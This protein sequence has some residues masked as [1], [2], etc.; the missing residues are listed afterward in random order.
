LSEGGESELEKFA[1]DHPEHAERLRREISRL[2]RLGL[3]GS[4]ELRRSMGLSGSIPP[5][6]SRALP[7]Q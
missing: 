4:A 2:R 5:R 1:A 7:E 6:E 3:V